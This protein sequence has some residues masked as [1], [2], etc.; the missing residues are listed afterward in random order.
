MMYQNAKLPLDTQLA[1]W[2][3]YLSFPAR[4][5]SCNKARTSATESLSRKTRNLKHEDAS[6]SRPPGKKT[7]QEEDTPART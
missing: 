4:R 2:H 1:D 7:L 5:H 6:A 3:P